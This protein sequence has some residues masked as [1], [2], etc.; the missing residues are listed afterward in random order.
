MSGVRTTNTEMHSGD[1]CC[2]RK[3][4][5]ITYSDC[6]FVALGIQHAIHVPYCHL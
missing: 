6:V 2:S 1:K 3:P 4:L 5:S